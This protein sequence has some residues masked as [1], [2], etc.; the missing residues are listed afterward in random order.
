MTQEELNTIETV[1]AETASMDTDVKHDA[2]QITSLTDKILS[3]SL[4]VE[5]IPDKVYQLY[6]R[7]ILGCT[8]FELPFNLFDNKI[9]ITFKEMTL[10]E[11]DKY[12]AIID[13]GISNP[14]ILSKLALL[15]YVS[16]ISTAEKNIYRGVFTIPETWL[17]EDLELQDIIKH[18]NKAYSECFYKINESLHRILPILWTGFNQLLTL[19]V[20][21]GIPNSF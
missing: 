5:D 9:S 14:F 19:L 18:I 21:K 11:A 13:K 6:I 1:N 2:D 4:S 8:E 7:S 12:H 10:A 3:K 16:D 17:S 20:S 15:T